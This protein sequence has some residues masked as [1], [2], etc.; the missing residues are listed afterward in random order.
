[1]D[2]AVCSDTTALKTQGRSNSIT[3]ALSAAC[4]LPEPWPHLLVLG[5][6][7][8]FGDSVELSF[9]PEGKDDARF[10]QSNRWWVKTCRLETSFSRCDKISP[11]VLW[12]PI[13]SWDTGRGLQ[14][15]FAADSTT[16][17]SARWGKNRLFWSVNALSA[18]LHNVIPDVCQ[19]FRI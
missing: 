15:F 5:K 8:F 9:A 2:P 4:M 16:E 3:A 7:W 12:S 6:L 17:S 14:C 18:N 19:H 1:M 10:N 11:N 13:S